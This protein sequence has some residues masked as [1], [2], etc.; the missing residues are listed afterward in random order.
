MAWIEIKNL[1]GV[2]PFFMIV[3]RLIEEAGTFCVGIGIHIIVIT[4]LIRIFLIV[5][6]WFHMQPPFC[7]YA[8]VVI[9]YAHFCRGWAGSLKFCHMFPIPERQ[10][11][12][13]AFGIPAFFDANGLEKGFPERSI[14]I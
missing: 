1:M 9:F 4:D 2:F 6:F 14:G 5:S 8:E 3:C 10:Q 13:L 12:P 11:S 7:Q